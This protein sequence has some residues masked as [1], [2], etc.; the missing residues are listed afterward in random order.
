[1]SMRAMAAA[2]NDFNLLYSAT[3]D[4]PWDG[5]VRTETTPCPLARLTRCSRSPASAR[6]ARGRSR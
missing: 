3:Y 1:M 5:S 2:K 4:T 6:A